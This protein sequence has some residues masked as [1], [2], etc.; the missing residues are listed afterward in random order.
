MRHRDSNPQGWNANNNGRNWELDIKD[1]LRRHGYEEWN[2]PPTL[3]RDK[4]FF[5]HQHKSLFLNPYLEPMT[6]DFYI[7]HPWK[8]VEGLILECKF[9]DESGSTDEK[10]HFA[11]AGLKGTGLRTIL[12]LM[13]NGFRSSAVRYCQRH[14]NDLFMVLTRWDELVR[15]F[16]TGQL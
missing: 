9:Q 15:M 13:G 12:L 1:R 2:E 5:V 16:N 6:L 10:L 4:P 7:Y 14:Q 11:V 8:Y 3:L